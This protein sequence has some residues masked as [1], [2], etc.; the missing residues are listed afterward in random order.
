M[1]NPNKMK[2]LDV[3]VNATDGQ[4]L[5][6]DNNQWIPVD[7]EDNK[8]TKKELI[9]EFEKNPDLFNEIMVEIRNRKINEIIK[10]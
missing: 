7:K 5:V 10:K 3:C 8:Y 1:M 4:V 2:L 9:D 6:L